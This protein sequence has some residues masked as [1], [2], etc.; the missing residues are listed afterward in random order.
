MAQKLDYSS[1]S[2]EAV[3]RALSERLDAIRLGQ[4]ISQTQL[5]EKSGVSRRT[6]TRL[7]AGEGVSFDTFIRVMQALGLSSQLEAF[8]PDPSIRPMERVKF[9]GAERQRARASAASKT[10]WK[11]SGGGKRSD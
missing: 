4:N 5:A 6:L 3:E 1:A 8:I 10:D 2:S 7:A 9:D 11:W